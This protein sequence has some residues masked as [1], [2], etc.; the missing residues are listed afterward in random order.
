MPFQCRHLL[1]A[2]RAGDPARAAR[3]LGLEA[4]YRAMAA[5]E[6]R[7]GSAR[8]IATRSVEMAEKAGDPAALGFVLATA[9]MSR[10]QTGEFQAA[11]ELG[12]R[13]TEIFRDQCSGVAWE[14]ATTAVYSLWSLH[15]LGEVGELA[16]RVPL[17]VRDARAR[18]DLFAETSS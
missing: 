9:G 1:L 13:A 8:E 12:E 15:Y 18:G 6:P 2:L 11:L 4:I 17:F 14:M 16:R 5:S 3:A 7:R 10:Y